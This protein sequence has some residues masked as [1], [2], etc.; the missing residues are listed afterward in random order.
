MNAPPSRIGSDGGKQQTL[1]DFAL[2]SHSSHSKRPIPVLRLWYNGIFQ[3]SL[4]HVKDIRFKGQS[5]CVSPNVIS[6]LAPHF[7]TFLF[8]TD[9]VGVG[10]TAR[11]ESLIHSHHK[12][13]ILKAFPFNDFFLNVK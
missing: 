9:W 8:H 13:G 2:R 4:C 12:R 10:G 5:F 3:H 7:A 6:G 1:V 11:Y